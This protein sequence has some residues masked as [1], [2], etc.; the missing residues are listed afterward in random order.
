MKFATHIL[1]GFYIFIILQNILLSAI[2]QML[3]HSSLTTTQIYLKSFPNNIMDDYLK[4]MQ[5]K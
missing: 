3:G 4:R 5:I 1:C 2:S